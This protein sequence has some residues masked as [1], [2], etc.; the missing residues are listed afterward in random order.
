MD[1]DWMDIR[2]SCTT[3]FFLFPCPQCLSHS[4]HPSSFPNRIYEHTTNPSRHHTTDIT[5]LHLRTHTSTN[6]STPHTP[7]ATLPQTT[8]YTYRCTKKGAVFF[9]SSHPWASILFHLCHIRSIGGDPPTKNS[10]AD[11]K[12]EFLFLFLFYSC[13][14]VSLLLI[15]RIRCWLLPLLD[16]QMD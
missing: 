16:R 10:K 2:S 11:K 13:L 4:T 1:M 14:L 5:R 12:K 6:T 7:H 3:S 15:R 9:L 8:T